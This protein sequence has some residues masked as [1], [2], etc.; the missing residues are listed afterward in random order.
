MYTSSEEMKAM[1]DR[2]PHL[3]DYEAWKAAGCPQPVRDW[4]GDEVEAVTEGYSRL[5]YQAMSFVP[6][7]KRGTGNVN[8]RQA[9]R[10]GRRARSAANGRHGRW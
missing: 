10:R 7:S 4:P 8:N 2:Y 1:R 9:V 3:N 5:L 6:V